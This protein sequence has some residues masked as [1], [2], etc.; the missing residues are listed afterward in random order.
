MSSQ[1]EKALNMLINRLSVI[2]FGP[3]EILANKMY[4]LETLMKVL[5][6]CQMLIFTLN[7]TNKGH[8]L[9]SY[10]TDFVANTLNTDF[11]VFEE[12]FN[13][14]LSNKVI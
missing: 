14:Y 11:H 6:T 5:C 9:N 12:T 2:I 4:N 7:E 10:S 8:I 1:G 3:W 13:F